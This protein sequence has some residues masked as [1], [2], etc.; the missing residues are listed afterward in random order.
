MT[1]RVYA[2]DLFCGAGGVTCGLK[3]AGFVVTAGVE[4]DAIAAKTYKANNENTVIYNTDIRK[5]TGE[6][7]MAT[8]PENRIDLIAACPPCQ[9]FSSLTSKYKRNDI[10]NELIFDFIRLTD[11]IKPAAIM[12]ENVPGMACGRG[13][14][15]FEESVRMLQGIG[16][17]ID[18]KICDVAD[19]GVPQHRRR[20][21][22]LGGLNKSIS[23]PLVIGSYEYRKQRWKT[24]RETI[25]S[26]EK[27]RIFDKKEL[28]TG[29]VSKDWNV[30]RNI[31]K[32][33]LERLKHIPPEGDRRCIPDVLRPDCHKNK[34]E[35]FINVYGRMQWSLPSP[36]I[37][38]GC[39]TLS[40]G[41]FG[42]PDE[43]RTISV[44]EA[45]LLQTFPENYIFKTE[46]IDE[47]CKMIGN[48]VPPLFAEI[49]AK[50]CFN[51][52]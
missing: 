38:G 41:R 51:S 29:V 37:T 23:V 28:A 7:L 21:V 8:S 1:E 52:F 40:K 6:T 12:L 20:L 9:G 13:K 42:H 31:S 48:A 44:Y 17:K 34:N 27:P 14:D 4:I 50:Q 19:Y 47:V 22:M 43:M 5:I 10:R 2:I 49:M 16:Y 18:Y 26:V 11:E 46:S 32:I 36:T 39:T 35:G 25:K 33:N 24:V 45:A 15:I 30:I 3:K